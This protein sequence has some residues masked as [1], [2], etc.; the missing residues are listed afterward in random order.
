MNH[1]IES[2]D[3]MFN[4]TEL[5]LN[6]LLPNL[7]NNTTLTNTINQFKDKKSVWGK[8]IQDYTVSTTSGAM[9]T[10]ND[11][12]LDLVVEA[13]AYGCTLHAIAEQKND[14]D[15]MA[16]LPTNSTGCVEGGQMQALNRFKFVGDTLQ[17]ADLATD[18]ANCGISNDDIN[19]YLIQITTYE[20]AADGATISTTSQSTLIKNIIALKQ[21]MMVVLKQ[22]DRLI[23]LPLRTQPQLLAQYNKARHR[24]VVHR[25]KKTPP[26]APTTT[27][28]P[29]TT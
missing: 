21:E 29:K 18:I 12:Y 27:T 10:K 17:R 4:N 23:V 20:N 25:N 8:W 13:V 15:L 6:N 19:T 16:K 5:E 22:I 14:N 2:Y 7:G 3:N 24:T 11:L 26:P 1:S 9:Q 28:N